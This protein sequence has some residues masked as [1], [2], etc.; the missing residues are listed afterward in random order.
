MIVS[1]LL[2]F[3]AAVSLLLCAH[4]VRAIRHSF[5]FAKEDLPERF[6]L[7]LALSVSYA[8]NAILPFRIG[9]MVRALFIAARLRLRLPYVLATVVAERFTDLWAVA[10]IGTVLT[11]RGTDASSSLLNAAALLAVAACMIAL[12]ALLVQHVARVRRAVWYAASVFN[13]HIRLGIVEFVWT[14]AGF[15]TGSR[16]R[17]GRYIVATAGMWSLYLS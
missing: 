11:I 15:V 7:L 5:L 17:S 16:L 2:V 8:L 14:V 1:E 10:L 9:E 13:E 6:G 12:C 4:A 3:G